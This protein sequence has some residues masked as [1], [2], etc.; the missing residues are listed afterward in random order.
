MSEEAAMQNLTST[1]VDPQERSLGAKDEAGLVDDG[2][3][4]HLSTVRLQSHVTAAELRPGDVVQQCDW[5]LHVCEVNVIH[6]AVSI[7]VTEFGF[8]LHYAADEQVQLQPD[9]PLSRVI[10]DERGASK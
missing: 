6:G 8:H 10:C 5:S 2:A 4:A 9:E 7:A 1:P 3:A